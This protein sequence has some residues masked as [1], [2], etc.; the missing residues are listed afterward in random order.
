[1]GGAAAL[2]ACWA[3]GS[4]AA[5]LLP[6]PIPGSLVGMALAALLVRRGWLPEAWARPAAGWLIRWMA[7][8]FV[9]AGVGLMAEPSLRSG[10]QPVVAGGAASTLAVLLVVGWLHQRLGHD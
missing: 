7:L 8:F 4:L 6:L 5:P 1:M 10:W 9:P 2:G 3:A